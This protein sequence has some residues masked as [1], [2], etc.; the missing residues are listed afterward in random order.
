MTARESVEQVF[1]A[2]MRVKYPSLILTVRHK[3]DAK[4][5]KTRAA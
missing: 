1:L 4:T 5:D 3:D 2:Q